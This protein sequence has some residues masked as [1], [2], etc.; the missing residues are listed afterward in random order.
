MRLTVTLF[1]VLPL[2]AACGGE[3]PPGPQPTSTT[4]AQTVLRIVS[5]S[6]N[7]FLVQQPTGSSELTF[8]QMFEQTH[9]EIALDFT[10]MGSVD[11]K[12]E[13]AKGKATD[14]DVAFPANQI[15]IQLGDSK[16]VVSQSQS[17][18]LSPVV[19][20]VKRSIAERLG[21]IGRTDLTMDDI[22]EAVESGNVR[23][24]MTN[25]TQSNSGAAA[26]F[27]MLYAFAGNPE[28]L[29]SEKLGNP[30]VQDKVGRILGSVDR[31]AGS[32][33]FLKDYFVDPA[34][35]ENYDQID[36][37][38]NY[39]SLIIE[40]N[41]TLTA[42]NQQPN[43]PQRELLYAITPVEGL[44]YADS[45]LAYID[46]GDATKQAAYQTLLD[47]FSEPSIQDYLRHHGRRIGFLSDTKNVDTAVFNPD[48]GL[49][50]SRPVKSF[51]YPDADVINQALN[52]Y[53][54]QLRRPAL[55]VLVVDIS[56]S[57]GDEGKLEKLKEAMST[58]LLEDKASQFYIQASPRDT[59]IVI[60]FCGEPQQ[61]MTVEADPEHPDAFYRKMSAL[62]Q[63]IQRLN[64][65]DGTNFYDAVERAYELLKQRPYEMNSTS[66][67]LMTDG[68]SNTDRG[69]FA[70]MSQK[71]EDLGLRGVVPVYGIRFGTF[72]PAQI[73]EITGFTGGKY[74]DASVDLVKAYREAKG[75]S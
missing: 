67:I 43:A 69:S 34:H 3:S 4:S 51:R 13:L 28:V 50:I 53:T 10:F 5:G 55:T 68:A 54:M 22:L 1:F 44:G 59:T 11:I 49:D 15:W 42:Q 39:E 29:T 74:F 66:V 23:F 65:C 57:M 70:K 24:A 9:P 46:H 71:I 40:A 27:A 18:M 56:G 47:Y 62:D 60:P 2:L 63:Q 17:V 12:N 41:Q 64:L 58:L 8:K 32:S 25:A 7:E 72:D 31:S 61:P 35:P 45:P 36:G 48:W 16:N 73:Q 21:W 37:M 19:F 52:L 14:F 26:Y 20:A 75:Y 30:E 38:F 33:G 6:E